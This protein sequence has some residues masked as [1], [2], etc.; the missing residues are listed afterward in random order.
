MEADGTNVQRIIT[1]GGDAENPAWSPDGR[2]I[3]FAWQ[4]SGS[5]NF[6]IYLHQLATGRNT[7]LTRG[8]GNNER[9]TWAPDGKHIAFQSNRSGTLQIY[10]M[11]ADGSKV[12]QLTNTG[13]YNEGPS[14]SGY[15]Q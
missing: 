8:T 9:P 10:S 15:V 3:A 4:R 2:I 11:L 6:D 1:E 5:G 14:W 12:R 13:R 7:Q